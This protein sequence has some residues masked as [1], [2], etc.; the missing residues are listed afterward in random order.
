MSK[1]R[2]PDDPLHYYW[3]ALEK[4]KPLPLEE[5]LELIRRAKKGDKEAKEKVIL[6][7]LRYVVDVALRE[8]W[9]S[10]VPLEDLISEGNLGLLK[11]FE[12]FDPDKGVRLVSYADKWIREAILKFIRSYKPL[13]GMPHISRRD[14]QKITELYQDLGREPTVEEIAQKLGVSARK[15]KRILNAVKTRFYNTEGRISEADGESSD[16][17]TPMVATDTDTINREYVRSKLEE[18]ME[19]VLNSD[20]LTEKEKIVLSEFF[21]ID[22]KPK[23]L[24]EIARKWGVSREYI[25]QLKESALKKI[26]KAFPEFQKFVDESLA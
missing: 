25:R 11:A 24:A 7:N 14:L 2:V 26:R 21:G 17:F 13:S 19:E 6:S 5:E 1:E 8:G 4:L 15:V 20:I 3:R 9:N 10:G 12:K 23:K 22:G 16:T 18:L